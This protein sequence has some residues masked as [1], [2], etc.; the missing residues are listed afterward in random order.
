MTRIYLSDYGSDKNDGL[1]KQTA[2]YSWKKARRLFAGHMEISVDNGH[3]AKETDEGNPDT[4]SQ[5]FSGLSVSASPTRLKDSH[6]LQDQPRRSA[7]FLRDRTK[8]VGLS[9]P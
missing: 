2:I 5:E 9:G 3:D 7:T 4:P 6:S 8:P 1:T